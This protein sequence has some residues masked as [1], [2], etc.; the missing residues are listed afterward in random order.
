MGELS[1]K[2]ETLD[3]GR[4]KNKTKWINGRWSFRRG[5]KLNGVGRM[6]GSGGLGVRA[7]EWEVRME[8]GMGGWRQEDVAVL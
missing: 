6:R 4:Q 7:V 5:V 1:L 2:L 8:K 3:A